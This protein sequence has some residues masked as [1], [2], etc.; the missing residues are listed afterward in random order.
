MNVSICFLHL[1]SIFVS[2]TWF[3]DHFAKTNANDLKF[4]YPP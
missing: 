2:L 4:T 1:G 3:G